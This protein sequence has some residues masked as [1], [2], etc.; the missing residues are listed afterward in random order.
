MFSEKNYKCFIGYLYNDYEIKPLHIMLPEMSAYVKGYASQ[1]KWMYFLIED[2][3]LFE[4]HN[5]I[6]DK[7]IVDIKKIDNELST[8]KSF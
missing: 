1:T 6:W 8:I 4:N 7:V 2:D 3:G 5:A